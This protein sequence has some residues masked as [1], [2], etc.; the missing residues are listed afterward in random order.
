MNKKFTIGVGVTGLIVGAV[1]SFGLST[2][3][4]VADVTYEKVDNETYRKTATVEVVGKI[5]DLEQQLAE[6]QNTRQIE[7]ERSQGRLSEI[8]ALISSLES[9]IGSIKS[10]G[11]Q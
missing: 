2:T 9:E 4:Q 5:S 8:D 6:A 7:V 3:A 10:K 11:V 1:L